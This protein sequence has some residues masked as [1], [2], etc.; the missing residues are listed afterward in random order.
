MPRHVN[1]PPVVAGAPS[2]DG[3]S[4]A[5]LT[6]LAADGDGR[7]REKAVAELHTL[8]L[9]AARHTIGRLRAAYPG[10]AGDL[11]D[12]AVEA[13]DDAVVRVLGRLESF[14]GESRFTTWAYGFAVVETAVKLRRLAWREREVPLGTD[15]WRE[16]AD[17][18][19]DLDGAIEQA[20][21]LRAACEAIEH[22]LTPRQRE[23]L[24]AVVLNGVPIDVLAERLGTTRGALYKV[25]HD[26]RRRLRAHLDELGLGPE[27]LSKGDE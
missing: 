27:T 22:V 16:P 14:R 4:R 11:D 1:T 25:V 26:A 5:W 18:S 23:V 13:A 8:L 21:I 24:V 7:A 2:L 19:V 17:L 9:G 10:L 15:G 12:I 20:E 6:L 3:D